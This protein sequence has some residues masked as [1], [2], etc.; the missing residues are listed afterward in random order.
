MI[1]QLKALIG[2]R[3]ARRSFNVYL[4]R[5][6]MHVKSRVATIVLD[7]LT[8]IGTLLMTIEVP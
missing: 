5:R 1:Q 8:S 6:S 3:V 2:W 7:L 4:D